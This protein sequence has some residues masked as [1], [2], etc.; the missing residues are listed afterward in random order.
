[1]AGIKSQLFRAGL[2]A[3]RFSGAARALAPWTAGKGAILLLHRVQPATTFTAHEAFAPNAGLSVT[4]AYLDALLRGFR[5]AGTDIIGLDE[6]MRR[7]ATD[8]ASR[9]FVCFTFDD[10]YRDNLEH[11][12][13][14]FQRYGAPFTVYATSGFVER[15]LDPWWCVLEHIVARSGRVRWRG[16][17]DE[18][19]Y[20]TADLSAKYL[21]YAALT[22]AFLRLPTADVR[23]QLRRLA[24]DHA[25][26][27]GEFAEREF[28]T[29]AELR[30]LRAGGADIGCHTVSHA[31]LMG[32]SEAVARHE[33]SAARATLEAE[34]GC[35][36]THLAYPYGK[37]DH[38]GPR[39]LALAKELGFA[40]ATTT[41]KGALFAAHS[42]HRHAL[43]RVEV[44]PSFEASPHYLQTIVSGLPLLIWNRGHRAII[45]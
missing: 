27:W 1:M 39:E 14:V 19:V 9:R 22:R 33:L 26:S 35:P 21:A 38:V 44:T 30:A 45:D 11:G 32:E 25:L 7:V 17:Q 41:R 23:V 36:V 8:G 31:R 6:A 42:Q 13:P 18:T 34:L 16:A 28:C 3:L 2:S 5:A 12:L 4:P 20:D 29:F 37:R 15:S 24:E 40:S 10:G 43:P